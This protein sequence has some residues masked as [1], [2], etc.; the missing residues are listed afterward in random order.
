MTDNRPRVTMDPTKPADYWVC[1]PY[2]F[3]H[4]LILS[5]NVLDNCCDCGCRI[6]HRPHA[7]PPGDPK[8][9]CMPCMLAH[10]KDEKQ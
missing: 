3:E 10:I 9:I 2:Q 4:G 1:A 8:I 6:Q 7:K 5:D